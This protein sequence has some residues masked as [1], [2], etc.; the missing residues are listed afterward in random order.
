MPHC[1]LTLAQG[2]G[3]PDPSRIYV[4]VMATDVAC[5][6]DIS[7]PLNFPVPAIDHL[8]IEQQKAVILRNAKVAMMGPPEIHG[9]TEHEYECLSEYLDTVLLDS[10]RAVS[11]GQSPFWHI[12]FKTAFHA[13][14][15]ALRLRVAGQ[16]Y[17]LNVTLFQIHNHFDKS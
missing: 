10:D 8:T 14:V 1:Q 2:P 9:I 11:R 5:P 16:S 7:V 17:D 4:Q 15:R 13:L 6:T 12:A 3:N